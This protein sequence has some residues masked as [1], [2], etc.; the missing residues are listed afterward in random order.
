ME[1]FRNAKL[2]TKLATTITLEVTVILILLLTLVV[3]QVNNSSQADIRLTFSTKTELS[4]VKIQNIMDGTYG[5]LTDLGNY[6]QSNMGN[7]RPAIVVEDTPY[8]GYMSSVYNVPISVYNLEM[9]NYIINT[10][11][12]AVANA[13]YIERLGVYFEPYAFDS[14]Q[15]AYAVSVSNAN[16]NNRTFNTL[17]RY[18]EYA[19]NT[20][21]NTVKSTGKPFI[22][23]TVVNENGEFVIYFTYPLFYN[24]EFIGAIAIDIL[25][26]TFDNISDSDLKYPS[27]HTS[28]LADDW[29]IIYDSESDNNIGKNVTDFL[30][31]SE[32]SK[33]EK[34]AQ[35]L[36]PFNITTKY[37]SGLEHERF[38]YP[39]Q[40]GD[41]IWWAH[42]EITASDLYAE[43]VS[44]IIMIVVV[45]I[46]CL[47]LLTIVTTMIIRKNLAPMNS[48]LDAANKMNQ[49]DLNIN[50][51]VTS[52]D[53]I[54]ILGTAF[55]NMAN[56]LKNIVVDIEGVL[57]NM[58]EGDFTASSNMSAN[59][60]GAFAPIKIS[61]V[62]IGDKLSDTLANISH[63]AKEVNQGAEGIA[64]GASQ[65]AAGTTEQRQIIDKF[66]S[67]T[68]EITEHINSTVVQVGETGKITQEAKDKAHE[69]TEAMQQM[70]I[71]MDT[72]NQS[73]LTISSV[74]KTVEDI[75]E[76]T[77]L[78]ALNAAIEAA[79]AGE[80]G[81]G[82]A[83]VANEIR[84]LAT[85][86]S[87]TVQEIEQI[88]KQSIS[89][90]SAG[91]NIANNTAKSLQQIVETIDKTAAISHQLLLSSEQQKASIKDLSEGT[92]QI[93]GVVVANATTSQESA[94]VS[95]ELAAQAENLTSML[96][97]FKIK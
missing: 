75:A 42:L 15:E 50:V 63:S 92:Q 26:S 76:Q 58:A 21:Y 35:A 46:I 48:L 31:P 81:K 49:G 54:G 44:L 56:T 12:S 5:V 20:Y 1:K 69:G 85:R 27:V 72:I 9:E 66:V 52:Q 84:D 71:S 23:D 16:T 86:S 30:P 39:V 55:I 80:S 32:M 22:S 88:I 4:G 40:V 59:Y 93:S 24:N 53:E 33:W 70:L 19:N 18:S 41:E 43:L 57:S 17:S 68:K 60:I 25:V 45:S 10:A 11:W 78:L 65:L 79:R 47:T 28:L 74:L 62:Q 3:N 2:S 95:E 67:T 73:S 36:E 91:Q 8:T 29:T 14:S 38:S 83:V 90:V 87:A 89:D 51:N 77:N 61:L 13:D 6:I 97:Y 34:A 37:A 7:L 96:G 94:A 82:F 64:L